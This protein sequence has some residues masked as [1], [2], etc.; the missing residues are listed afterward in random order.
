MKLVLGSEE[1]HATCLIKESTSL[2]T[3]FVQKSGYYIIVFRPDGQRPWDVPKAAMV[4]G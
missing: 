2:G 1:C 3:F 4:L